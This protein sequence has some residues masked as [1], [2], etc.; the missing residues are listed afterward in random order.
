LV[1]AL[2]L[3]A[4][5]GASAAPA[6]APVAGD[7]VVTYEVRAV[8]VDAGE[9]ALDLQAAGYE[10]AARAGDV[11]YVLGTSGSATSLSAR[12]DLS[13]VAS[14]PVGPVV[15]APGDQDAIL[16]KKLDGNEYET[17]YGGYRTVDGFQQFEEDL[18]AAYPSTVQL[19]EYG[20][21]YTG[22]NPLRALCVTN[23]AD[24]GCGLDPDTD[25]ARFVLMAQIHARELTTSEIAWRML[26]YLVDNKGKDPHVNALLNDAEIW[27]VPEANP[28]GIETA[29]TGIIEDGLGSLSDAW[30]R[31]NLNPGTVTCGTGSFSQIGVDL[32]RNWDAFWGGPGSSGA[33]CDLTYRGTSA[34]SEPETYELAGLFQDL[35][36]DQRPPGSTAPAPADTRGALIS[37]HTYS[38]LVLFPYGSGPDTPNDAGLR[39]M[40]FRMT[41]FNGYTAGRPNEILYEVT[42]STDDFAYDDLGIAAFTYEVGP[43]SGACSGFHPAYTCQETFWDL[44]RDAILYGMTAAQQPYTQGLGPTII[45]AESV[46]DGDT[47]SI[48]GTADDDAYGSSGVEQPAAQSVTSARMFIGDAPWEG[49]VA[50]SVSIVGSGTQVDLTASLGAKAKKKRVYLQAQDASGN[51]GPVAVVWRPAA[52][53]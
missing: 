45:E 39:S 22:A 25:K 20:E 12:A 26:S 7:T 36:E 15:T 28:D 42:G 5:P 6:P 24:Q 21:S 30:Q 38:N 31:K 33:Q 29:E 35:F 48:T 13:V 46:L 41:Y 51:W 3:T 9:L 27:V 40:A 23:A 1:P 10:V 53:S 4:L 43:A 44:N 34:A 50:K 37:M 32:N 8:G 16:P 18:A 11:L 47:V 14:V 52:A 2:A 49:G 17:F 19:V